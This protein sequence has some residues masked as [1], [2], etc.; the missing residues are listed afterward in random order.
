MTVYFLM[1]EESYYIDRLADFI[2]GAVLKV[3]ER[4]FNLLTFFGADTDIDAVINAAKGY[5]L[6][7]ARLV[8][9]VR[10]AQRLGRLERLEFYLKHVQPS[11]VLVLCYKGGSIDRRLKIAGLI[12]KVGVLYESKKVY[13]SQ[14]P[15]F[16]TAYLKR[17]Q[18]HIEPDAATL[19]GECVGADL[20]RLAGELDKLCI[21][22]PEGEKEVTA[23]LVAAHV[24]M[25][26]DFNV[27]ELQDALGRKDVLKVMI[28]ANYFDSN[29]K[30]NSIQKILPFLFKFFSNVMLA[31]NAP[32]MTER[33]IAQC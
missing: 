32:D 17:R 16:I 33:G 25:S 23:Q 18:I 19:L 30:A 5:P 6:G 7:A 14:L 9:M 24:G 26:K 13:D 8:V 15:A 28:I 10:E 3:E 2:V 29:P 20:N 11:T 27:F 4:D 31:Y 21:A 12:E 22:L 1:G